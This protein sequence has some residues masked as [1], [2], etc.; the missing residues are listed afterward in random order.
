MDLHRFLT[1]SI[2]AG[3]SRERGLPRARQTR[4]RTAEQ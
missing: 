1:G 4:N 3:P 2:A